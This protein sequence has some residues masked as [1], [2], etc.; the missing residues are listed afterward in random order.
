MKAEQVKKVADNLAQIIV[1]KNV[2]D[3]TRKEIQK[4]LKET[5]IYTIE[6]VFVQD[7]QMWISAVDK[8]TNEILN[9][10]YFEY[11]STDISQVGEPVVSIKFDD[12][13]KEVFCNIT[14][15][16]IGTPMAIFA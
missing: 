12:K 8:K 16:N 2:S 10:A 7:R 15:V 14:E 6:D 13:G 4:S 11:A 9:G 5:E 1:L 3:R